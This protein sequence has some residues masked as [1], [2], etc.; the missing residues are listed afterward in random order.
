MTLIQKQ[1]RC[2][3]QK[4]R[5]V[6]HK[7]CTPA[8]RHIKH[9][10]QGLAPMLLCDMQTKTSND[11]FSGSANNISFFFEENAFDDQGLL[12]QPK[13]LSINKMGHGTMQ[14]LLSTLLPTLSHQMLL[15]HFIHHVS[16]LQPCMTWIPFSCSGAAQLKL[17]NCFRTLGTKN[18]PLSSQCIFSR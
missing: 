3:P 16:L 11:Y 15:V 1:F 2:S 13:A 14:S 4:I 12:R 7:P 10:W 17:L 6:S 5:L 18:Q 8:C 9:I